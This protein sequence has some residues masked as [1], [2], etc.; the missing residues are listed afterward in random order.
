MHSGGGGAGAGKHQSHD[1]L[2]LRHFCEAADQQH[3]KERSHEITDK[4]TA[5][6]CASRNP[7][8]SLHVPIV[9]PSSPQKCSAN[10]LVGK[11]PCQ[12]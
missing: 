2:W 4:C 6:A 1:Q 8:V 7:Q 9:K 11:K 5:D 3:V 10:R 12:D